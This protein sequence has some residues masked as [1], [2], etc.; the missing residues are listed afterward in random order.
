L[1]PATR[2]PTAHSL[3]EVPSGG[4]DRT[5]SLNAEVSAILEACRSFAAAD[6]GSRRRYAAEHLCV[7][8]GCVSTATL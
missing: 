2:V 7:L 5:C 8:I 6:C 1:Q 3:A 4:A